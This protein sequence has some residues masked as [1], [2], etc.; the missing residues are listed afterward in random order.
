MESRE[1][2]EGVG[3]YEATDEEEEAMRARFAELRPL[4]DARRLEEATLLLRGWLDAE[5]KSL[6][7]ADHLRMMQGV[8]VWAGDEAGARAA[9]EQ[10]VEER[11]DDPLSWN[12]LASF[13]WDPRG[14][15]EPNRTALA[16]ADK[17]VAKARATGY[18]LRYCLN[19]RARIAV[20]MKRWD[21]LEDVLR[22]IL[23]NTSR[24]RDVAD[25]R[26]EDDFLRG[27]PPD[28][29]DATLLA[30]YRDAMTGERGDMVRENGGKPDPIA[31]RERS[32]RDG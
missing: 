20:A 26:L 28:A 14:G 27:I 10:A 9:V 30:R 16:F 11:P 1:G 17:A 24:P 7:R 21:L 25:I 13:L 32:E 29:L 4:L 2:L 22:D 18:M 19:T 8:R 23:A 3:R 15:T 5:T 6:V 31:R 12:S